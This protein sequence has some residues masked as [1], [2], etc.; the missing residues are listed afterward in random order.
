MLILF[1]SIVVAALLFAYILTRKHSTPSSRSQSSVSRDQSLGTMTACG[2]M[3]PN[4]TKCSVD[5][6]TNEIQDCVE[7]VDGFDPTGSGTTSCQITDDPYWWANKIGIA[8]N[9]ATGPGVLGT[10]CDSGG[11]NKCFNSSIPYCTPVP[12]DDYNPS[13]SAAGCFIK[14]ARSHPFFSGKTDYLLTPQP[15]SAAPALTRGGSNK[16]HIV[17]PANVLSSHSSFWDKRGGVNQITD[18]VKKDVLD[19]CGGSIDT[20]NPITALSDYTKQDL[21]PRLRPSGKNSYCN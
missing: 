11:Q 3:F 1:A 13:I 8:C 6:V 21:D 19:L 20:S 4:C 7:C 16:D 5:S 18:A 2:Q 9:C 14:D 15:R 10:F 12:G 17:A